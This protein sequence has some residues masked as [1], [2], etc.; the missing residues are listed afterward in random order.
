MKVKN[1]YHQNQFIIENGD[2]IQ[3]QSYG[4]LIASYDSNDWKLVLWIDYDYSKTTL[5]HLYLFLSDYL[6]IDWLNLKELK[7]SIQKWFIS[8]WYK[9]YS[10]SY[11]PNMQ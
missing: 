10:I 2:L 5:K 3:F 1:F 9:D 4:S 6:W 11:D 7:K 8:N